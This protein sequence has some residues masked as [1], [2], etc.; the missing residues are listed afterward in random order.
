M[1]RSDVN[2]DVIPF[3]FK[4]YYVMFLCKKYVV[5]IHSFVVF[6]VLTREKNNIP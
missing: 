6:N 3:Y 4:C 1:T 5:C 2:I